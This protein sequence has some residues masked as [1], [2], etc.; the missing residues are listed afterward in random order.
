MWM[1]GSKQPSALFSMCASQV[2]PQVLTGTSL[3]AQGSAQVS[4]IQQSVR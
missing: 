4:T 3:K 1:A 2:V